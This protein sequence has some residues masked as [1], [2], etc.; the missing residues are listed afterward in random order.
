V[1]VNPGNAAPTV[2][3]GPDQTIYLPASSATL[4]GTATDVD[5]T[6]STYN[7]TKVSGPAGGTFANNNLASTTV[8]SLVAG[9]YTFR[10]TATDNLGA[11]G[12]D[13]VVIT[14][15]T[16]PTTLHI[17]AESYSNMFGIRTETT[18]DVGGGLNVGYIDP[19]DWMDY[20]VNV[21]ATGTYTVKF[22]TS[23]PAYGAKLQLKKADGTVLTTVSLPFTGGYQNWVTTT[24][25]VTLTAGVQTI[26][27]FDFSPLWNSWNFNW[28]ELVQG[29]AGATGTT[30]VTLVP[31]P[32][33]IPVDAYPNPVINQMLLRVNNNLT[34]KMKVHI[35]N[36][37]G[38]GLREM[39]FNKPAT[40]LYQTTINLSALRPGTYIVTVKMKDWH[41]AITIIK[42]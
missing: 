5:G 2:N 17:E 28:W 31:T 24:A 9:T 34:G 13:D 10:L 4:T 21:P 35:M 1:T 11:T 22:R 37:H 40:G 19:S 15:T 29:T 26:R 8:S 16:A 12:T 20:T 36:Q 30:P 27:V 25:T 38:D 39:E 6:I 32:T 3:A 42:L 7:W 18:T 23:T 33:V 14:V 41:Q